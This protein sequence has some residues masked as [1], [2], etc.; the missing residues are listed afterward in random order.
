MV[1]TA[2]TRNQVVQQ[3]ARGFE[4]HPVRQKYE[5][6]LCGGSYFWRKWDSNGSGSEW[7]AGGKSTMP[8]PGA[9]EGMALFP[10]P[11]L[12]QGYANAD[13]QKAKCGKVESCDPACRSAGQIIHTGT[14]YVL[15]SIALNFS[16]RQMIAPVP[17]GTEA[18]SSSLKA[19]VI[20]V[21]GLILFLI[22]MGCS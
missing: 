22:S 4:S 11:Q 5:P 13:L 6:P 14:I 21:G 17:L 19:P 1:I 3:W 8:L 20:C 15:L 2:L 16:R 10:Q 9:D 18:L 7:S 12:L